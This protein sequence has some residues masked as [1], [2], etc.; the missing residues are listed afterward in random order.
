MGVCFSNLFN[1]FSR[2]PEP[3]PEV[4]PPEEREITVDGRRFYERIDTS[5]QRDQEGNL[6]TTTET[7]ITTGSKPFMFP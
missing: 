4:L 5:E 3:T 6:I 1:C 2:Q 7:G